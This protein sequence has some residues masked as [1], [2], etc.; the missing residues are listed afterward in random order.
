MRN[1]RSSESPRD[2]E[3]ESVREIKKRK[4]CHL[5]NIE[6]DSLMIYF[7]THAGGGR[8]IIFVDLSIENESQAV[9]FSC[10]VWSP[11]NRV[12]RIRFIVTFLRI[13]ID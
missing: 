6:R 1:L 2:C 12:N 7:E 3:E 10:T 8:T 9:I 5:A 11:G 13:P 4:S